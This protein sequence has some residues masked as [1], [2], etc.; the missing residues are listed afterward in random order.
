MFFGKN[1]NLPFA[2]TS[3]MDIFSIYP[4]LF[5]RRNALGTLCNSHG[6]SGEM[7]THQGVFSFSKII[8]SS[9]VDSNINCDL[10]SS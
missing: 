4:D 10:Y 8:E 5:R 6:I 2:F 1:V 9:G 3:K 7:G